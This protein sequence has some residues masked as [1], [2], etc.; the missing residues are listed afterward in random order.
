MNFRALSPAD[1]A[2]AK[3][4]AVWSPAPKGVFCPR[5]DIYRRQLPPVPDQF[6]VLIETI[7]AVSC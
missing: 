4:E 6:S 5:P 7:N 1:E 2:R 3:L